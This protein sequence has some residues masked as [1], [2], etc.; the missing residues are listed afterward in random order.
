MQTRLLINYVYRK[1]FMSQV[2]E[3]WKMQ[4]MVM[5]INNIEIRVYMLR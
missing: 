4:A 3:A 5:G 1:N 2:R